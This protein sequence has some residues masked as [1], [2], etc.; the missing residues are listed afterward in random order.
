VLEE[1]PDNPVD[2]CHRLLLR[3]AG[4]I[5][6]DVISDCRRRLGDDDVDGATR[7]VTAAVAFG[8]TTLTRDDLDLLTEVV[9][10]VGQDAPSLSTVDIREEDAVIRYVFMARR[11]D[12]DSGTARDQGDD[13]DRAMLGVLTA[14]SP[15]RAAWRTWRLV[16][17]GGSWPPPKRVYVVEIDAD[18]EPAP[19]TAYLQAVAAA[20]G[21]PE[22]QVEVYPVHA[23]L[24]SYQHLARAYGALLWCREQT[25]APRL[26]E[27]V[28]GPGADGAPTLAELAMVETGHARRLAGYLRGGE[29]VLY[30]TARMRDAVTPERGLVVPMNFRTDGRWIWS[31]AVTYYLENYGLAPDPGLVAHIERSNFAV[32]VVDGAAVH[33]ALTVLTA[34][35]TTEPARQPR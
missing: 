34:P 29:P 10:A 19:V 28:V 33:R 18:V 4:R 17:D 31:D 16:S 6:D 11:P 12:D 21:E 3:L 8:H 26:A 2:T 1:V 23:V 24:P 15:I 14:D 22:P 25:L 30:T 32:P 5:P 35:A 27:F 20:A 13:V 7:A 9:D